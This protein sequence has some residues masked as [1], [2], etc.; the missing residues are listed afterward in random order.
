[1]RFL[2]WLALL[3]V[4]LAPAS[5]ANINQKT[6]VPYTSFQTP[7]EY[8]AEN[9]IR[10]DAV[11]VYSDLA[12][13]IRSWRE[14]GYV[15]QTM[16]GF[17]TYQDYVDK[18]PEE[19]QTAAD[20][21]MLTCGPGSYYMVPTQNRIRAATEY[22]TRAIAGGTSAVVPEEP[23][24]FASAGYSGAFRKAWLEHYKEPWQDPTS[25]IEARWKSERLK[26]KMEHDMVKAILDSAERQNPA[27][28]RMVAVHSPVNYVAWN[29]AFSHYRCMMI[30]NLQ[31]I[32]GQV[33]TGTARSACKYAGKT[34]ERTFENAFLEYSS[35]Y[36]LARGTGKRMWF[37]M[38]PLE[39]HPDRTMEDYDANYERTL[40]ASLMFPE[41]DAYE[42]LPWPT[43]I[44]GRVPESFATKISNIVAALQNMHSQRAV[45]YDMGT[46]GIATFVADSMIWQR[47]A[48]KKSNFDSF[49]GLT[50]PLIYRGIPVDVAQFER[51]PEKG[52]LDRYKV[53][54]LSYDIMKPARPEYSQAIADWVR[55]MGGRAE[56]AEGGL[57]EVDL[58]RTP[59]TD[60][61]LAALFV[62]VL[63]AAEAAVALAIALNF[64]N[65]HLSID[66]DRGNELR[67]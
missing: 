14:K 58:S 23:E 5:V 48:P 57:R 63:A 8:R 31:E 30:P 43:R 50:L 45:R 47:G 21:T 9:D 42:V 37:L 3:P 32:V 34:E 66:V 40:V 41:I 49:Y 64:Y 55:K 65:N 15:V 36:N 67:G 52:Y 44:Y 24:F 22:F 62:I 2:I 26:A 20:G 11:I 46:R 10:T 39:D 54:L 7:T 28:R 16:Y 4:A 27:V 53:L 33:W 60:G 18:H 12:D 35:L 51:A 38:D 59:V 29:V 56:F 61:Q 1:M 13:R 17:R 25:S 19:V 6:R